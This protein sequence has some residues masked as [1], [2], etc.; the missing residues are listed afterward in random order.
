MF[1]TTN[2]IIV[3]LKLTAASDRKKIGNDPNHQYD[4]RR[5]PTQQAIQQPWLQHQGMETQWSNGSPNLPILSIRKIRSCAASGLP[6]INC[7]GPRKQKKRSGIN[8]LNQHTQMLHVWNIY[9]HLGY[10]SP[11][12]S[13][14][15]VVRVRHK[16]PPF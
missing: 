13:F 6:M 8:L 11:C 14:E 10:T 15:P 5:Q 12:F 9:L 1:Q 16:K 7:T 2:Q 4:N 3:N